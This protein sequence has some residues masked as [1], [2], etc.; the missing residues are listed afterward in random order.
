MNE[1]PSG[2]TEKGTNGIHFRERKVGTG[3][4]LG[5]WHVIFPGML[6]RSFPF[7]PG[8]KKG[9]DPK[10]APDDTTWWNLLPLA[11]T[12]RKLRI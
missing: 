5:C 6:A 1:A 4:S 8:Q 7:R 2:G 12:D 10:A 11:P 9:G 3:I